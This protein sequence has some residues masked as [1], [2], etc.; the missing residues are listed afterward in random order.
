MAVMTFAMAAGP[1]LKSRPSVRVA[2]MH[3]PSCSA[4]RSVTRPWN[5]AV[6]V[7]G[8]NK[9]CCRQRLE[10]IQHRSS[11]A[12]LP[13]M[14]SETAAARM[15]RSKVLE[16]KQ[17]GRCADT[18]RNDIRSFQTL[19]DGKPPAQGP[20][21][22][23]RLRRFPGGHDGSAG[24]CYPVE[25]LDGLAVCSAQAERTPEQR[26]GLVAHLQ[27]DKLP[28]P[29]L[30]GSRWAAHAHAE[31]AGG[32]SPVVD[33]LCAVYPGKLVYALSSPWNLIRKAG[34]LQAALLK[35]SA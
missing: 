1:Q 32:N 16:Q 14:K 34:Q 15:L 10:I 5:P 27:H 23:N 8:G 3:F 30:P 18:A 7:I 12:V 29:R 28:G 13:P 19:R 2:G 21:K 9:I 33:K 20:D 26:R 31:N 24:S 25:D 22:I 17:K 35:P 6:A 4:K 11:S